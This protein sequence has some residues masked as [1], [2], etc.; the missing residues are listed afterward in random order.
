MPKI[1]LYNVELFESLL[2]LD[3]QDLNIDIH[4]DY[5]VKNIL[6]KNNNLQFFLTHNTSDLKFLLSFY[7]TEFI[8]F[9]LS[10][11]KNLCIDNFY[12]GRFELNNE[13]YN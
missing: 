3:F 6:F 9:D 5:E 7:D 10:T 2:E 13:L 4:N 1:D 11:N 12:R 8:E